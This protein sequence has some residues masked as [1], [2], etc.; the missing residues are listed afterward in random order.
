M[1]ETRLVFEKVARIGE[2]APG[3]MMY[4]EVGDEPVCL[5]NLDGEI[6]ALNDVCTHE[7]ASLAD[8]TVEGD[9]VECP[10]HGGAFAIRTGEPTALPCV[11]PIE[12]YAVRVVGDD[13]LVAAR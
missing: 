7:D 10:M 2:I 8:G 3:E 11:V 4:V 12:T 1:T 5:I 9:E 13:V 6:H